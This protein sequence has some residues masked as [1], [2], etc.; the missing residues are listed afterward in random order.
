M[1]TTKYKNGN[2]CNFDIYNYTVLIIENSKSINTLL[3]NHF[4]K[5]NPNCYKSFSVQEG[6]EILKNNKINFILLDIDYELENSLTLIKSL[7]DSHEKIF[8]LSSQ[9]EHKSLDLLYKNSIIDFICKDNNLQDKLKN[10]PII[11]NNLKTNL[12]K[13]ILIIKDS[14]NTNTNLNNI[15]IK[16]LYKVRTAFSTQNA[17]EVIE[18]ENIC[19]IIVDIK[20]KEEIEDFLK[21]HNNSS[22]EFRKIP[23]IIIDEIN[24]TLTMKDAL[25]KGA[26]DLI[27]KPYLY[28]EL[29]LKIDLWIDYKTK[30]SQL[31]N[32]K[33]ILQEYKDIVD[34]SSIVSKSNKHGVIT[35]VNDKFCEISGY[36]REELIGKNHNVVRHKDT[37]NSNF[38]NLWH[39]VKVLKKTWQGNIKN[40]KK[41][42]SYY[43]VNALIKPILDNNNEIVEYIGMRTD[44]TE[45]IQVKSYF[46]DKLDK[47]SDNLKDAVNLS[48]EYEKAINESNIISRLDLDFNFTFL[49]DKFCQLSGFN[50]E[51]LLGKHQSALLHESIDISSIKELQD[52]LEKGIIWKGILTN[53]SREGKQY[54]VNAT[55][56]PIKDEKNNILE[57]IISRQDVTELFELHKDIE[58][59][60][61]EIIY[62][63]GE[64]VESR[65][66]ETGNHVKRVAKYSKV[67]A[68][69]AGLTKQDAEI[70]FT[71]SPMHD[72]GKVGILDEIL[73]K[74]G[75]LNKKEF[76]IMK[77]HTDIGFTILE[78]STRPILKAASIVALSHHEKWDGSGYPK[79]LKKEDIHIFGR[80]TA[81]ADVFDAL[82]SSRIYKK[83][84]KDEDIF[85]YLIKEKAKHF[86]PK[87]IDLFISNKL[88]FLKIRD[89][90]VD[91]T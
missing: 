15:F 68:L 2:S 31:S 75:K 78:G 20:S 65:S 37:E 23:I 80:I 39:T 67:L 21:K 79:G 42:G 90:Y 85:S 76:D 35:Y 32:A 74:P 61:R 89:T 44:I 62:R 73:K 40:K 81:I 26:V 3:Y 16:R 58:D 33:Q 55:A 34:E 41:D 45:D 77:T 9:E 17:I 48:K 49:N 63:M 57:Y 83:A 29:L 66:K 22:K 36:K 51:E 14:T 30:N 70:L 4:T 27:K 53:K 72:I 12:E 47:T 69:L 28:E 88:K 59:T 1:I 86:D 52:S 7:Q 50:K 38:K 87:L 19:L 84:W 54:W 46:K 6:K 24:S 18:K 60:Q 71:A 10:I 8:V 43:W 11:I 56:V 13:N 25:K 5:I 82:G 64:I 91:K